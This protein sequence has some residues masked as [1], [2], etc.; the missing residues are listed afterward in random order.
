M[1]NNA[2]IYQAVMLKDGDIINFGD[3]VVVFSTTYGP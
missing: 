3:E 2:R 1:V